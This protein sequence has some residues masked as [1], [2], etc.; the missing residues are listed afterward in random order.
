MIQ[1]VRRKLEEEGSLS[2]LYV[3]IEYLSLSGIEY[4]TLSGIEYLT[5]R[6]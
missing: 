1:E 4:L 5:L 6:S 3:G 2:Q